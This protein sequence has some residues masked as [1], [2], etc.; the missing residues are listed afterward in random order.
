MKHTK[1]VKTV[2][3]IWYGIYDYKQSNTF[4]AMLRTSTEARHL[5]K[6]NITTEEAILTVAPGA[7]FNSFK[8][9]TRTMRMNIKEI[10][11][12]Y[13][14]YDDQHNKGKMDFKERELQKCEPF[15][16]IS[17]ESGMRDFFL[18]DYITLA[19]L[20]LYMVIA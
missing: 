5:S 10:K 1:V 15:T 12:G 11:E 2:E 19:C 13:K 9:L 14:A 8:F 4:H 16:Y 18:T 3:H 6:F 17:W 7:W 20:Y